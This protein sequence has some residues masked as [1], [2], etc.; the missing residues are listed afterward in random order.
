[1]RHFATCLHLNVVACRRS[2]SVFSRSLRDIVDPEEKRIRIGHEFIAV[3][4]EEAKKIPGV[5]YL[6]QGTLYPD[7]IESKTPLAK[8]GHKIKS[9]HNVGGLP[10]NMELRADRAAALALQRRS[11]RGRARVG[12]AGRDRRAPAVPGSRTRR[13]AIIGAIDDERL[14][15]VREA[16][17]IV[18]T[19]SKRQTSIR[20]RGSISRC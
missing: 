18:T 1:M 20:I 15:V 3:F 12:F 5:K 6:V 10:E 11:A 17:A 9:H 14:D 4:E 13:F 8:A 7:V 16:D 2:R 19:K